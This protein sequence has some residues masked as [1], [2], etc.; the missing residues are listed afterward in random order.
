MGVL[1]CNIIIRY[2]YYWLFRVIIMRQ[3]LKILQIYQC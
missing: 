2:I 1:K 3:A